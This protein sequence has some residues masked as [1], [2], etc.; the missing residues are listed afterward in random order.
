MLGEVVYS[1]ERL[2]MLSV[3]GG[4]F[5]E[6]SANMIT[7]YVLKSLTPWESHRLAM[8]NGKLRRHV[9]RPPWPNLA[10]LRGLA[11]HGAR[12]RAGAERG[13][14]GL[15]HPRVP[16][17]G[18]CAIYCHRVNPPIFH[19]DR[20]LSIGSLCWP[21]RITSACSARSR[22]SLAPRAACNLP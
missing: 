16:P 14:R 11:S 1:S 22:Q 19:V 7:G 18:R 20:L 12:A 9:G 2:E 5:E 4:Q 13:C 10:G 15:G 3:I 21:S 8:P 6:W 17:E